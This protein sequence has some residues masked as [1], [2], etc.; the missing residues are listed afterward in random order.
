[1]YTTLPIASAKKEGKKD[2]LFLSSSIEVIMTPKH[3]A[4]LFGFPEKFNRIFLDA[5]ASV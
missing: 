3:V 2:I 1:M 5:T 4:L